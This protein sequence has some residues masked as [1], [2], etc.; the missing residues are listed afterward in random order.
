MVGVAQVE[1]HRTNQEKTMSEVWL[2]MDRLHREVLAF[3]TEEKLM[4]WAQETYPDKK[5]LRLLPD[6][7]DKTYVL[8]NHNSH[9]LPYSHRIYRLPVDTGKELFV[10]WG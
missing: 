8:L 5:S 1:E 9:I 10:Y 2:F 6:Y 7:F 4:Q 3:S